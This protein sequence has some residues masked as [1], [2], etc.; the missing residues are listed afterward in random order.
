MPFLCSFLLL[1]WP[2]LW[3]LI[4]RAVCAG[5]AC[6]SVVDCF[7]FNSFLLLAWPSPLVFKNWALVRR[8]FLLAL[9]WLIASPLSLFFRWPGLP[10]WSF[11]FGPGAPG[12]PGAPSWAALPSIYI[13][14]FLCS[15]LPRR[16]LKGD[17]EEGAW[18]KRERK[19]SSEGCTTSNFQGAEDQSPNGEGVASLPARE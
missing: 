16:N 8:C 7:S 9:P 6:S 5:V 14:M 15:D 12:A 13:Y 4:W 3:S 17:L 2:S 11:G 18:N 19:A 10:L 1:A